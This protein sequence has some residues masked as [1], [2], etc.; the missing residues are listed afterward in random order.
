[1]LLQILVEEA[2]FCIGQ[3]WLK[4]LRI[5]QELL[6]VQPSTE[7]PSSPLQSLGNI[8]GEGAEGMQ[9]MNEV[10]TGGRNADFQEWH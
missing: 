1:M 3:K 10:W 4:T 6:N 7:H 5:N 8:I 9:E 2:S